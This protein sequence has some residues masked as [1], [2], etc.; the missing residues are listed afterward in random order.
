MQKLQLY[1]SEETLT[2]AAIALCL[3]LVSIAAYFD[4]PTSLGAFIMGAIL[5][6]T[7]FINRIKKLIAPLRDVFVAIF[8]VSVGMLVDPKIMVDQLPQIIG[9]CAF[10]IIGK[11]LSVSFACFITGQKFDDSLKIGFSLAQIG[12]F[13]YIV[14]ALGIGFHVLDTKIYP[15]LVAVSLIT[16]FTSPLLIKFP[17]KLI[18]FLNKHL[19]YKVRLFLK[20]YPMWVRQAPASFA[21][22]KDS[23]K[24]HQAL[25]RFL[26]NGI[27]VAIIFNAIKF[28]SLHK[29]YDFFHSIVFAEEFTWLMATILSSP[30]I[31]GMLTAFS[32]ITKT[33]ESPLRRI[34]TS[35]HIA[36]LFVAIEILVLSI[37]YIRSWLISGLLLLSI[38]IFFAVLY[39][40]IGALYKMFEQRLLSNLNEEQLPEDIESLSEHNLHLV[41]VQIEPNSELAG[42]TIQ[43]EL[44]SN[45]YGI[46]ILALVRENHIE[47][48]TANEQYISSLDKL[49]VLGDDAKINNF[50]K[51]FHM[52]RLSKMVI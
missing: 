37:V 7:A 38:I 15:I 11:A 47:T 48:L 34:I 6:E 16:A 24:P 17:D 42:K 51:A 4:Y 31:Y 52:K 5:A 20:A 22:L 18:P 10:I 2:I 21:S 40:K 8:F 39:K 35:Q 29:L 46:N 50:V 25:V 27:V 43:P 19:S 41:G 49:L 12:E 32:T 44:I 28:L 9:I 1:I 3:L 36:W 30:F 45:E 26:I 23:P 13:S 33:K 14:A